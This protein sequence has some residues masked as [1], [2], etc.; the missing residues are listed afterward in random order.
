MVSFF[1]LQE[2]DWEKLMAAQG[3]DDREDDSEDGSEDPDQEAQQ[4]A[5][6][7]GSSSSSS[8]GDQTTAQQLQQVAAVRRAACEGR[9]GLLLR[10]KGFVWLATRGDHI[11]E[12]SQAGSLL[13][14]STGGPWFCVLPKDAWP[15]D[16]AAAAELAADFAPCVGDRR[17]ELVFIGLG[18]KQ[19]LLRAALDECLVTV[20]EA[21]EAGF[22]G[23]PDPFEPWPD[24]TDL[25]DMDVEEGAE[26]DEEDEQ[27]PEA[28]P[29]EDEQQ[30]QQQEFGKAAAA[31]PSSAATAAAAAAAVPP[32]DVTV[33]DA[34]RQ[35]AME[36]VMEEAQAYRRGGRKMQPVPKSGE[37]W[38]AACARCGW[39][40]EDD[41]YDDDSN[42]LPQYRERYAAISAALKQGRTP[43]DLQPLE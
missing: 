20:T 24:V 27:A 15:E 29:A 8:S 36:K 10:S 30:Q 9:F 34:N 31:P 32:V 3:E 19:D 12:W 14:F 17:Q 35:L 25:L 33:S 41:G 1:V 43:C 21:E 38:D 39:S 7:T 37:D 22:S 16:A 23:L 18:L 26:E 28:V 4:P 40:C 6:V 2:P 13:S 5:G 11:G 42:P